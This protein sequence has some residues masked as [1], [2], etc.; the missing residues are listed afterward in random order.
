VVEALGENEPPGLDHF[1]QAAIVAEED[2]G[3][4]EV[5]IDV[6]Y[7]GTYR[8]ADPADAP[9]RGLFGTGP[10]PELGSSSE[11][12]SSEHPSSEVGGEPAGRGDRPGT[13]SESTAMPLTSAGGGQRGSLSPAMAG[14]LNALGRW[15]ASSL[16]RLADLGL[17]TLPSPEED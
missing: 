5:A 3:T 2:L 10:L 7:E 13:F 11:H 6:A 15:I 12:P 14:N 4:G 17:E 1:E 16:V 8:L 9:R